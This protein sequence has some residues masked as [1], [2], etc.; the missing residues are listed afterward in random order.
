MLKKYENIDL[1]VL[2]EN[3]VKPDP[4]G[5][6]QAYDNKSYNAEFAKILTDAMA[7]I[8]KETTTIMVEKLKKELK[9]KYISMTDEKSKQRIVDVNDVVIG[10]KSED[11]YPVVEDSDGRK[12]RYSWENQAISNIFDVG[13]FLDFFEIHYLDQLLTF[14]GKPLK[15]GGA[16]TKNV[17]HIV[18][19]GVNNGSAQDFII[20]ESDDKKSYI[21]SHTKPI[22]IMDMKL[23]ELDPYGEEDWE[24]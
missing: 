13:K 3:F 4:K 5:A 20:V 9:G 21:L 11:Y 14:W 6:K 19:I 24:N 2:N 7:K 8:K 18:R 17:K 10:N 1:E 12:F 22:K 16:E 15:G 23:K